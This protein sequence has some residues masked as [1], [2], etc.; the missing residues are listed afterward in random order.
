VLWPLIPFANSLICSEN[1]FLIQMT[2]LGYRTA[3]LLT[4]LF[5]LLFVW[6]LLMRTL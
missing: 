1:Y 2:L 3:V 6:F 5:R 4:F